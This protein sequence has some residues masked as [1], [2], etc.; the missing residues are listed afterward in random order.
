MNIH[1]E[2]LEQ[3]QQV[4][5]GG[6]NSP[7]R[8]F[9][10][11]GG[12]PL[13]I[14]SAKGPT[15]TDEADKTYIDYVGSWG[16]MILGHAHPEV[17]AAVKTAAESGT[18]F[19]APTRGELELAKAI[20]ACVPSVE[21][22]RL[23]NSGTEATMS[24]IRLARGFTKREKIIKFE[25]CY[26]GHADS[27]LIAAGSGAAT[28]GIPNSPG[29]T[30]GSACDTLLARFNNLESVEAAIANNPGEIACLIIEPIAGNMGVVPPQEGFLQGLRDLC[31]REGIVLIFDEVMSGFRVALGGAQELYGVTPDLTTL[32]KIIGGGLPVG[33]YGGKA[34]IMSHIAPEGDVYQAGTLSGNPLAVAAGLATLKLLRAQK[35]YDDLNAKAKVLAEGTSENIRATGASCQAVA[36]GSM[37]CLFFN[38]NPVVDWDSAAKSDTDAYARFF[39]AMLDGGVYLAPSQYE[40]AFLSAAHSDDDI[41][42]TLTAQRSAI[43]KAMA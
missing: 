41:E 13:F 29:V 15:I 26:H 20:I 1:Q 27:F 8:A 30:K 43:E 23:V 10:G 16:P 33:A 6:V 42:N 19:G 34:E 12:H 7:V 14:K 5:P 17:I 32:G 11:V 31:T 22:V 9:A 38:D 18:S 24:A 25:G 2:L 37:Q 28:L 3:S 21:K 40:A 35:F 39:H 4:I 36:I